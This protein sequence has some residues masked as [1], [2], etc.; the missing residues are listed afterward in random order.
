MR[1]IIALL[2]F[3]QK[4]AALGEK[5]SQLLGEEYQIEAFVSSRFAGETRLKK[6]EVSLHEWTKEWFSKA[7]S[8]IFVGACGIA[9]RAIAPFV[10]DKFADPAVIVIDE[11]GKFCISLMSGHVGGANELTQ[12]LADMLEAVPVIT[13]ATDL[14]HRFA[15]D[16]FAKKNG[17]T[18]TSRTLAKEISAAILSGERI[19]FF[20]RIPF[21]E[22]LPKELAQEKACRLNICIDY[23]K[24]VNRENTL[25]LIPKNIT[26]GIGCRKQTPKETISDFVLP[27]LLE[28]N[29]S[30][31]AVEAVASI[32]LK[33]HEEGLCAFCGEH[34]LPY[35]TY[36]AQE[37]SEVEGEF[38][39][40]AFVRGV[41]GVDNVCERSA[42]KQS[43]GKLILSKQKGSGVTLAAAEKPMKLDF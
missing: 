13:T 34:K 6:S 40:S 38:S 9:V 41:T 2:S 15:V 26:L 21:G 1:K 4:G 12:Q 27:K 10:K 22:N 8:L 25:W 11:M 36:S 14:N 31:E 5:L 28:E 24:P 35:F 7:D 23:R 33:A 43:G 19:G 30:L 29:I 18:I 16:V 39:P 20:S 32:D 17:L 3:T 37:L 42:V